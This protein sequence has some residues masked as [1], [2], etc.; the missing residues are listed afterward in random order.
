MG[1]RREDMMLPCEVLTAVICVAFSA[2]RFSV[3][4]SRRGSQSQSLFG[5][6]HMCSGDK[7]NNNKQQSSMLFYTNITKRDLYFCL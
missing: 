2:A 4:I 1:N 3:P 6:I 7:N 5:M